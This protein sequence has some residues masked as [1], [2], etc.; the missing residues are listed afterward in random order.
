MGWLERIGGGPGPEEEKETGQGPEDRQPAPVRRSAP[1]LAAALEG[2]DAGE[3][4]AIL[5]MGIGTR[6]HLCLYGRFARRIRFAG[7]LPEPPRGP[8]ARDAIL[9]LPSDPE[10][11]YDVV[12]LWDLL[13]WLAPERRALLIERLAGM[14]AP[15]ARL[16]AVVRATRE[17]ALRPLRH[18]PLAADRVEQVPAGPRR[19]ADHPLLPAEMKRVLAPFRVRRA[20]T[21]RLGL[22]EY[23]AVKEVG[24]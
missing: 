19:P 5:D 16:Y 2:L 10:R 8:E 14:T 12:L 3:G 4:H 1:A 24:E 6:A 20:F 11:P 21:L 23:L 9:A 7:F 18:T 13:D 15:G 17:T 22:R